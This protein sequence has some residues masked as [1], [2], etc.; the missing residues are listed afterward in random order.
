M[1]KPGY[2]TTEFWLTVV[3]AVAGLIIA[4]GV[5]GDVAKYAGLAL[6][7][8]TTLGYGKARSDVKAAEALREG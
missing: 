7:A 5:D 6:T 8:L 3:A 4:S 2:K 1:K